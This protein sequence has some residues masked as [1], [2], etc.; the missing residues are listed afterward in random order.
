MSLT[1]VSVEPYDGPSDADGLVPVY[2]LTVEPGH[3]FAVG[4]GAV[5]SNSKR[6]SLAETGALIAHGAVNV[7]E[8]SGVLR[9]TKNDTW[10]TNYLAGNTPPPAESPFVYRRMLNRLRGAGVNVEGEGSRLHLKALTPQAIDDMTQGRVV[11]S[12]ETVQFDKDLRPVPGGLFDPAITGGHNNANRWSAIKLAEPMPNPVFEEPIRRVLGLTGPAF[13]RIIGGEETFQDHGTGPAAIGKALAAINVDNDIGRARAVIRSGRKSSRD[14]AIKQLRFLSAAK[15]TGVH[16]RDWM[17]D[18]APVLP[19]AFRPVGLLADGTPSVSDANFLYRELLDANSLLRDAKTSLGDEAAGPERRT[20]YQAL[21]AVAGLGD[22]V[23]KK[24]QQKGVRGLLADVFGSSGKYSTAQRQLLSFPTD[25]VSRGTT[26]PDPEL[27]MDEI[28][29][30]ESAAFTAFGR[31]VVRELVRSGMPPIRALQEVDERTPRARG[32]LMSEMAR[33][34]VMASRAPVLHRFGIMGFR[35]KLTAGNAIR[36]SPIVFKPFN[37]DSDGDA[38]NVH[39]TTTDREAKDVLDRMLPSRNLIAPAD[40]K[41]PLYGIQQEYVAG[42]TEATS[43]A[44]ATRPRVFAKMDDV[45]AA[46]RRGELGVR[47]PVRILD[48]DE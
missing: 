37:L 16:P 8:D 39:V 46:I 14:L 33:R 45:L 25:G 3:R 44:A 48:R 42:V 40:R 32:V 38:M 28:G 30:P 36:F 15:Q 24:S 9:G 22:P 4:P 34:P 35:P 1:V 26:V 41:S 29:L 18:K 27:G 23:S 17:W 11:E 43:P 31:H 20:A 12:G 13:D 21:K 5:V 2:D 19:P 10:W 7:L 6:L 47:D